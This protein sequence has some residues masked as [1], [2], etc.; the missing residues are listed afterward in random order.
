[1]EELRTLRRSV[2]IS[3]IRLAKL[4]GISA[5][6]IAQNEVGQLE[7]TDAETERLKLAI[8]QVARENAARLE[9]ALG[10]PVGA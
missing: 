4:A 7:L 5:W 10:Q 3:Q 1:M 9:E 6:R 8:A 2:G